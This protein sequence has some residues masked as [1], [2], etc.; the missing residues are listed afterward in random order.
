MQ[1]VNWKAI[2]D[3]VTGAKAPDHG[4]RIP[5]QTA[6]RVDNQGLVFRV[7]NSGIGIVVAWI[8]LVAV[9]AGPI[10]VIIWRIVVTGELVW[11]WTSLI[12][13]WGITVF[14]LATKI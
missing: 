13:L 10:G 8:A 4:P 9:A 6:L 7:W 14:Q 3:F 12:W 1:D 2:A 11:L 5:G